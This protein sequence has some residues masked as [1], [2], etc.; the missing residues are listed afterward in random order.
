MNGD[1]R[2]TT[3][4]T[5]SRDCSFS[6]DSFPTAP[7]D[8]KEELF[9]EQEL[10]EMSKNSQKHHEMLIA[11]REYGL[12]IL[13]QG[14]DAAGKD[15]TTKHLARNLNPVGTEITSFKVPTEEE[16]E[17]DFLWRV[18][19]RVPARGVVGIHNRSHY[20]DVL[21]PMVDGT[22]SDE[23]FSQRCQQINDFERMLYENGI[24][25]IKIFLHISKDEQKNRLEKRLTKPK[26]QWKFSMADLTAREQWDDFTDV[27]EQAL[28]VTHSDYAPW[29]VIPAD[30]KPYRNALLS[31][32]L[33]DTFTGLGLRFPKQTISL[34]DIVIED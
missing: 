6:L 24:F 29:H 28:T 25:L 22:I 30:D 18:H 10:Q 12:L 2:L 15:G 31:K 33:H 17:H 19:Q 32:L 34:K 1:D 8:G 3:E 14:K 20:E 13:L 21:V 26:K 27:Y 11:S 7:E 16:R 5:L 9:S 23:V 4:L